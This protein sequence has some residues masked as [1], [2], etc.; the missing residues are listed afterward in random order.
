MVKKCPTVVVIIKLS[1][2]GKKENQVDDMQ[3]KEYFRQRNSSCKDL[4]EEM[5]STYL[6]NTGDP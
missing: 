1:P 6:R 5:S 4:E 2:E 3:E